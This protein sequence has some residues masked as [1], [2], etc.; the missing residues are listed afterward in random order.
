MHN[1]K[2]DSTTLVKKGDKYLFN[3]QFTNEIDK[4]EYDKIVKK[5][6]NQIKTIKKIIQN[7][8]VEKKVKNEINRLKQQLKSQKEA[9]KN[10]DKYFDEEIKTM[11][12]NKE[13]RREE[14]KK[15][16]DNHENIKKATLDRIKGSG[17][18][19]IK[20]YDYQLKHDEKMLKLYEAADE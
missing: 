17:E 15:L 18:E 11:Q 12:K 16:I 3:S 8:N 13:I 1:V 5:L 7:N 6:R 2:K 10:F 20:S 9:Y 14:L 4:E 19:F